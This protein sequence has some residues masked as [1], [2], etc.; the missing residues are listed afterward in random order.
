MTPSQSKINDEIEQTFFMK[1]QQFG[2]ARWLN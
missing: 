2:D 1:L